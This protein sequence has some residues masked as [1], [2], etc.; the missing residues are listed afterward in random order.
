MWKIHDDFP[1]GVR[2]IYEVDDM[3]GHTTAD[4]REKHEPI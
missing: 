4:R 2:D 1:I 3:E